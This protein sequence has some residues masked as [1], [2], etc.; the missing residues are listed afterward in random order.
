MCWSRDRECHSRA[1][2]TQTGRFPFVL[3]PDTTAL[4]HFLLGS[5]GVWKMLGTKK[6]RE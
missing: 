1:E 3:E 6:K 5:E 2:K 4:P